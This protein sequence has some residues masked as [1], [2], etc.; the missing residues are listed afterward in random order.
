MRREDKYLKTILAPVIS[1]KSTE[2]ADRDR[3][4]VFRVDPK[5]NKFDIREAVEKIFEVKV[6]SVGVVRSDGKVKRFK[7]K[8]GSR[9]ATKKAYVRLQ[10]GHDINF[11]ELN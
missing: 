4:V 2:I 6:E 7:G 11:S 3:T 10:K 5:A 9:K 1:E 8:L